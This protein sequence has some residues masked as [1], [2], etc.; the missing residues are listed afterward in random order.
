MFA[1][2]AAHVRYALLI[3]LLVVLII[4]LSKWTGSGCTT[5]R[6]V[7]NEDHA[8]ALL[9]TSQDML[10]QAEHDH[11]PSVALVHTAYAAAYL[12]AAERVAQGKPLHVAGL[13]AKLQAR[14]QALVS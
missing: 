10:A 9:K 11:D 3:L 4:L 13:K 6:V 14:Q 1:N 12:D 5:V 8:K 2:F 7:T